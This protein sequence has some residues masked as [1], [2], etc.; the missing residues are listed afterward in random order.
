MIHSG[1]LHTLAFRIAYTGLGSLA[2]CACTPAEVT[3]TWSEDVQLSNGR[4]VEVER[5][6]TS[7]TV[8]QF[9]Q[10]VQYMLA[11]ESVRPRERGTWLTAEWSDRVRPIILDLDE[12]TREFVMVGVPDACGV[13]ERLTARDSIYVEFRYRQGRWQRVPLSDFSIGHASNLLL[14]VR[15]AAETGHI[16]LTE[17]RE[18]DSDPGVEK[19][20]RSVDAAARDPCGDSRTR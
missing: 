9:G 10:G 5:K 1:G 6:Q 13:Y 16:S 15:P 18:R 14:T 2:L 20:Y 3:S 4:V 8:G 7:D 12:A 17:K 11:S 19:R